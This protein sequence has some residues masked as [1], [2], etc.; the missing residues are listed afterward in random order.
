M[1][2]TKTFLRKRWKD[3]DFISNFS[4]PLEESI[5][6]WKANKKLIHLKNDKINNIDLRGI[7]D[8]ELYFVSTFYKTN[9]INI[10]FSYG[11]GALCF[12]YGEY[13]DINFE[14]FNFD[15]ASS[16]RKSEIIKCNFK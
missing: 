14:E 12:S 3:D 5:Q 10:D 15:R 13:K 8:D 9:N 7:S 2:I 16:F 11:K 6:Q 1:K 4:L